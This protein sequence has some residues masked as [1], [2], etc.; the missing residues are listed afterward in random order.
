MPLLAGSPAIDSAAPS[1][2]PPV[3]QRGIARPYGAGCDIGAFESAP[4]Y[5]IR[6]HVRGYLST[7]GTTIS[8]GMTATNVDPAGF[9]AFNGFSPGAYTVTPSVQDAVF[10]LSNQV[11][12]VGP[13]IVN[14]DFRPYRSNAWTVVGVSNSVV[15]LVLAGAAGQTYQAFD[16]TNLI[17]WSP[18][19]NGMMPSSGTLLLDQP[20][21]GKVRFLRSPAPP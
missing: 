12:N 7:N 6:G 1:A 5:T 16:S 8:V 10:V 19:T 21:D 15:H 18:F 2:C 3:D 13:D 20:A 4:P 9:F 11:L 17:E 14:A